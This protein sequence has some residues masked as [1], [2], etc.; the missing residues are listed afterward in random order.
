M[1][2]SNTP[3]EVQTQQQSFDEVSDYI[4]IPM[5]ITFELGRRNMQ[6]RDILLL[7]PDSVVEIPKSA[8]ENL[9]V[10]VNGKLVGFGEIL[11][12]EGKAGVRLTDL[13]G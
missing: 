2:E 6:V 13:C 4:D 7:R 10:Y 12:M 3:P 11:E 9:D 1:S 8:G 5:R